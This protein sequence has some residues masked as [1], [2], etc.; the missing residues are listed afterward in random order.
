MPN[1]ITRPIG[2]LSSYFEDGNKPRA[3]HRLGVEHERFGFHRGTD[4]LI[5]YRTIE[6]LFDLLQT[7][8]QWF[9]VMEGDHRIAL[10]RAA[11]M[12]TL[13][14]GGQVEWASPTFGDLH[15][16]AAAF[17]HHLD[18]MAHAGDELGIDWISAG[19][20]P[21][22]PFGQIPDMPKQ[23]YAIMKGYLPTQGKRSREMMAKTC[24]VQCA[25]DWVDQSDAAKK[26]RVTMAL[27]PIATAM[28]ANSPLV[29]GAP[30]GN[31]AERYLTWLD[32]DNDR[33]G[34]PAFALDDGF[35][36]RD[37]TEYALDVPMF[38]VLRDERYVNLTGRSFREFVAHGFDGLT[39]TR[40]D[41]ELH[42]STLFT[43]VRLKHFMEVRGADCVGPAMT[44]AVPALWKGILYDEDA[45]EQAWEL[46][47]PVT[48]D[49][50]LSLQQGVG[51]DALH[52][53]C[54]PINVRQLAES[55]LEI[56]EAGL[57]R[58]AA[59]DSAGSDETRFLQPLKSA[60]SRG[61]CPAETILEHWKAAKS[62]VELL[63]RLRLTQ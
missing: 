60:L 40:D 47:R 53:V 58:Q 49:R 5:D 16:A 48:P 46:S 17:Q 1:D 37:Y 2:D 63:E 62:T 39:P 20:N 50:V 28:F 55:M 4:K 43:D 44:L 41:W 23:R 52:A 21:V 56:A 18:E 38:F 57:T 33:C 14:P 31:L 15:E 51:R 10:K 24:S 19:Y 22:T 59:T 32:C 13:E 9:P 3:A 54:G 42:L 35:A 29:D 12:I 30:T 26:L 7:R 25:F 61:R 8:Y 34:I 11:A 45:L 27:G 6:Q 36:F